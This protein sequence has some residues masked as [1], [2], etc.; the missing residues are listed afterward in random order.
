MAERVVVVRESAPREPVR[1]E[2]PLKIDLEYLVV[3][4]AIGGGLLFY[5]VYKEQIH[6]TLDNL[7]EA[8]PKALG[9]IR[10]IPVYPLP[11]I[12][13]PIGDGNPTKGVG[14]DKYGI[15]KIYSSAGRETYNVYNSDNPGRKEWEVNTNGYLNMECTGYIRAGGDQIAV[16]MRGGKHN[17]NCKNCGCCIIVR[18]PTDYGKGKNFA[19]ECPHPEYDFRDIGTK[20]SY[21]SIANKWVGVKGIV[22]NS[23]GGVRVEAWMDLGGLD[24]SGRPR[25]QWKQFYATTISGEKWRKNPVYG[26]DS[27]VHFRIDNTN[28]SAKFMSVREIGSRA[29]I[30]IVEEYADSLEPRITVPY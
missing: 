20:F 4:A 5:A 12:D 14:V 3:P 29:N 15:T 25:N 10:S 1:R 7:A 26:P 27:L 11:P 22:Y 17:D 2:K 21:N 9:V 23:G 16:K 13:F 8:I 30:A 18:F 24:S 6:Q 19:L 28:T